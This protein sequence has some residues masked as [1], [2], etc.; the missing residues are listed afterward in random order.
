MHPVRRSIQHLFLPKPEVCEAGGIGGSATIVAIAQMPTGIAS[1]NGITQWVVIDDS[2]PDTRIPPLVPIKLLKALDSVHEAKTKRLTLREGGVSV[3]LV[4]LEPSEH[5]TASLMCFDPDGWSMPES[6]DESP[7][8]VSEVPNPD[9]YIPDDP[10]LDM[11]LLIKKSDDYVRPDAL[12]TL[13]D[14]ARSGVQRVSAITQDVSKEPGSAQEVNHQSGS[15]EAHHAPTLFQGIPEHSSLVSN[16]LSSKEQAKVKWPKDEW[17]KGPNCWIRVHNKPR[18]ALF[19]PTGTKDG[20]SI[21][22]LSGL[23][24]TKVDFCDGSK[25]NV[26]ND[27]W[28]SAYNG[29]RQ[30][31]KKWTGTTVF[32]LR[33]QQSDHHDPLFSGSQEKNIPVPL[34]RNDQGGNTSG[35]HQRSSLFGPVVGK[36]L[37]VLFTAPE[38]EPEQVSSE[39]EPH[40]EPPTTRKDHPKPVSREH[41]MTDSERAFEAQI[42][43]RTKICLYPD[44]ID[45]YQASLQSNSHLVNPKAVDRSVADDGADGGV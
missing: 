23:R 33:S 38:T 32:P 35:N 15:A 45:V 14:D 26:V 18:K 41:V 19:C 10:R 3:D 39:S 12:L 22:L 27:E 36:M 9:R 24:A 30:L 6:E 44:M 20:P 42:E 7:F 40:V 5:Q 28:V 21:A 11:A 43:Y 37:D 8:L 13:A 17:R 25:S 2:S 4:E 1:L 29:T 34:S 16:Y 31:E